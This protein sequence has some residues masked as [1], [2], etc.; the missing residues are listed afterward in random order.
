MRKI[1][2][3]VINQIDVCNCF[4][5]FKYTNRVLEK[6]QAYD[7][8]YLQID[9][10]QEDELIFI[11]SDS[12]YKEYM[13]SVY[14]NRLSQKGSP[15][16]QYYE[17]LR[18]SQSR[19]PYCNFPTRAVKELDHYLPKAHFPGFAVTPNNLVPICKDCN[20]IKDDYYNTNKSKTFIHP[21]YDQEIAN[22]FMFLKCRVIEDINIG[23]E[24]FIEKLPTWDEVFFERVNFHF[25]KLK[26]DDLYRTDFEAEFAVKFEELKFLYKENNDIDEIKSTIKRRANALINT[27]SRPW[28]YA[29]L[30]GILNSVWFFNSY[31][32]EKC[33]QQ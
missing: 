13:I 23:F 17:K 9:V 22:V 12:E 24:F 26:I 3:P 21:Y 5:G 2:K 7:E 29:G 32:P 8:N 11:S 33:A 30:N 18:I 28:E 1:D 16:Y 25:S 6:S 27:M 31:F 19:C 15:S 10:F 4:R 14:E 20:G